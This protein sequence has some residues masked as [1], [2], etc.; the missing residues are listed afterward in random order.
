MTIIQTLAVLDKQE[1]GLTN[2]EKLKEQSWMH[3]P[4]TLTI[5]DTQ[6]TGQ[7]QRKKKEKKIQPRTPPNIIHPLC[8][9]YSQDVL[10]TNICKQT[11]KIHK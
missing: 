1:T 7:K 2:L 11:Q 5:L 10:E 8:Y 6:D 3:N 4:E 9:S